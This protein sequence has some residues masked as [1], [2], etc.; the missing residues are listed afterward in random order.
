MLIRTFQIVIRKQGNIKKRKTIM[1]DENNG[2]KLRALQAK[3]IELSNTSISFSYVIE[4]MLE[5]AF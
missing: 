3:L 1:L 4:K 2:H 5:G